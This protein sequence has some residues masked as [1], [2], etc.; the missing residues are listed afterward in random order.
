LGKGE[1]E[2]DATYESTCRANPARCDVI[3]RK[4]RLHEELGSTGGEQGRFSV[5]AVVS[6]KTARCREFR[7]PER[8]S[9]PVF[10][11]L[12]G[13]GKFVIQPMV[14]PIAMATPTASH[15]DRVN[16]MASVNSVSGV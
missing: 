13:L 16:P 12:R 2:G 8:V 15:G 10:H 6:G 7:R 4:V 14:N 3:R 1:G 11:L 9:A 5:G